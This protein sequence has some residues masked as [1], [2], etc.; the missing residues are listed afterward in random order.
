MSEVAGNQS[1]LVCFYDRDWSKH[2]DM[3]VTPE[4]KSF[5][6]LFNKLESNPDELHEVVFINRKSGE[7]YTYNM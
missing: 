4:T 2:K 5:D 6:R 3:Q 1:R 7:P